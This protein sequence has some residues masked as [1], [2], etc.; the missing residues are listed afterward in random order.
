MA[1]TRKQLVTCVSIVVSFS[2]I[3]NFELA[4]VN[5]CQYLALVTALSGYAASR[6]NRFSS[7]ISD[8]LSGLTTALPIIAGLLLEGGY[9]LSKRQE[10]RSGTQRGQTVRPPLVIIANAIILIYSSVVIT[11]LG[12]HAAPGS[13]LKCGL[14]EGWKRMFTEKN[15]EAIRAIQ[16]AFSCCGFVNAHDRA[17][18]FPSKSNDV[19]ACEKSF[20]RHQGCLGPWKR[21]VQNV[22]GVLIGVVVLVF[23]WQVSLPYL[24]GLYIYKCGVSNFGIS[25]W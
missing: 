25:S 15:S 22:A 10:R 13:N 24:K 2:S 9:D 14:E 4:P 5:N 7:P 12:T 16:D 18:P 1:Y 23:V 11:L 19:Y 8:V 6:T 21:E 17:W 20:G 3:T